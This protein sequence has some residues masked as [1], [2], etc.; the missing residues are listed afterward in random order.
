MHLLNLSCHS[1]DVAHHHELIESRGWEEGEGL[2]LKSLFSFP[3][4]FID[5][6]NFLFSWLLGN[7]SLSSA[8]WKPGLQTEIYIL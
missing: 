7:P 3:L 6:L 2:A 5:S 1:Q 8:C 4:R